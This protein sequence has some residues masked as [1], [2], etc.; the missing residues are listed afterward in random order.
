MALS[1]N[2]G[3]DQTTTDGVV[4]MLTGTVAQGATPIVSTVWTKDSGPD[5]IFTAATSWINQVYE[6]SAGTYVFRLT[7]TDQL[8]NTAS[9]TITVTVTHDT[10]PLY[11]P[12]GNNSTVFDWYPQVDYTIPLDVILN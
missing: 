3:A 12:I 8:S 2:A 1:V 5:C 4:L 10:S 6:L 7:A 11:L 9:D